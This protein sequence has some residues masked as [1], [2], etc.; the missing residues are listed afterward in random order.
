M[1]AVPDCMLPLNV[2]RS[3]TR[4]A[5]PRG[6]FLPSLE[7]RVGNSLKNLG[8]SHKTLCQPWCPKLVTDLNVSSRN[9]E[10]KTLISRGLQSSKIKYT[11]NSIH[12]IT[13]FPTISTNII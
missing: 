3:V 4:W 8:P 5:R 12:H 13:Y 2:S 7:K 11:V 9:D 1:Q 10:N 6:N